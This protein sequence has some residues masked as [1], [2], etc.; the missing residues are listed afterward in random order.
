M[1]FTKAEIN[2]LSSRRKSIYNISDVLSNGL[3]QILGNKQ[4]LKKRENWNRKWVSVSSSL[5][6]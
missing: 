2:L 4:I 1:R 3:L 5:Q 6:K